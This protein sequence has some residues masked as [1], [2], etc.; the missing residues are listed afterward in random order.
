MKTL[1]RWHGPER[2]DP[3]WREQHTLI[4]WCVKH[5]DRYPVLAELYHVPNGERR[6]KRTAGRLKAAGVKRG[7]PDLNLDVPMDPGAGGHVWH[8]LRIEMKAP[9]K[10]AALSREQQAWIARLHQRDYYV[11][12][13]DTWQAAWNV[14]VMYL[15]LPDALLQRVPTPTPA[16]RRLAALTRRRT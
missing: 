3:E 9:G 1:T 15:D 8:G 5:E 2:D 13:C 10:G 12:V 6:S 11:V 4:E 14:L 16:R 7:P